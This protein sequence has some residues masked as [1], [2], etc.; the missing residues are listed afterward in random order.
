MKENLNEIKKKLADASHLYWLTVDAQTAEKIDEKYNEFPGG[1]FTMSEDTFLKA[2]WE[3]IED[4]DELIDNEEN[5]NYMANRPYP[6]EENLPSPPTRKNIFTYLL[7]TILGFPIFVLFIVG[8]ILMIKSIVEYRKNLKQYKTDLANYDAAKNYNE[9]IYPQ[10]FKEWEVREEEIRLELIDKINEKLMQGKNARKELIEKR[11]IP[12]DE[13]DFDSFLTYDQLYYARDL[14]EILNSKRADSLK[15]AINIYLAEEAQRKA[16]A[17]QQRELE[18]HNAEMEEAAKRQADAYEEQAKAAARQAAAAERQTEIAK[19]Q[20]Q[21]AKQSYSQKKETSFIP[22]T[23][24]IDPVKCL[25]CKKA[26]YCSRT[27]CTGFVPPD[28][29]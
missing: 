29:H 25:G 2:F 22:S 20:A 6:K 17:R 28:G 10:E 24:Q 18:R 3:D 1:A 4:M 5:F 27:T 16:M 15:E 23:R 19:E 12:K 9:N 11:Y 26:S 7:M 8:L 21:N 14:L 13:N